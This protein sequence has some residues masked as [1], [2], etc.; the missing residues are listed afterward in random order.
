MNITRLRVIGNGSK[1]RCTP[2]E[3]YDYT[4]S[5]PLCVVWGTR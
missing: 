5:A 4:E 2:R 1:E 3:V